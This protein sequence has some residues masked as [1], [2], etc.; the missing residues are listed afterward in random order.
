VYDEDLNYAIK[1][2]GGFDSRL[3]AGSWVHKPMRSYT[4]G[5][6]GSAEVDIGATLAALCGFTHTEIPVEGDFF[7]AV[8]PNMLKR[9]GLMEFFHEHAARLILEDG[10]QVTLDGLGGG[11]I[12]GG[13]PFKRAGLVGT[14]R[15]AVGATRRQTH[16]L[17]DRRVA[18]SVYE[19]IL[20]SD[21]GFNV[22][23]GTRR[24]LVADYREATIDE[25]MQQIQALRTVDDTFESIVGKT[26]FY[27]RQRRYIA[28]QAVTSRPRLETLFPF[29]DSDFRELVGQIP[30]RLLANKRM[31]LELF[32][33]GYPHIKAAKCIMSGMSFESAG[34]RVHF[35]GRIVRKLKDVLA[36]VSVKFSAGRMVTRAME[37]T[38][39]KRWLILNAE[40]RAALFTYLAS[41]DAVDV[42]KLK[43][44]MESAASGKLDASGT[45]IMLTASYAGLRSDN[46]EPL[47][48]NTPRHRVAD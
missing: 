10:C 23:T 31:Y 41:S 34:V 39:W 42:E 35:L 28:L 46:N 13:L 21:G 36:D 1:L 17:D 5:E 12:L 32:A 9:F 47:S 30:P 40:F 2:S 18:E 8:Y 4:W 16:H 44:A 37:A 24:Q 25:L 7:S 38:Q 11:D 19:R 33:R 26:G 43:V 29:M 6:P 22:L 45:R 27:N 14:M 15:E 20:V 3:I 48:T